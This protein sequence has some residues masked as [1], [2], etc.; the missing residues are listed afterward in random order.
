MDSQDI[1][2]DFLLKFWPWLEANRKR[3][4]I[5]GVA[6][7]VLL[8][9]WF[10]L[11]TQRQQEELAAGQA[12]TQFQLS[13]SPT[14]PTKQLADGYLQIAKKYAGTMAAQRAELQAASVMFD[15]GRYA[16]AQKEFQAFLSANGDSTLAAAAQTGVA[17]CLEA[18]GKLDDALTSY[19]TVVNRYPDSTT[20]IEAKYSCGRILELQGKLNEAVSS[21]Q[22]VARSQL[23]GSLASVSAQRIALLRTKLA[24]IKP[25]SKS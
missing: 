10:F 7:L 14:T 5:V 9:V 13:Q 4:I 1:S 15:A 8:L 11:K 18:Q 3:L 17:A 19:Q 23:A 25:V 6:A 24:A 2:T 20:A 22:E 21:Y 16:D 12:Y